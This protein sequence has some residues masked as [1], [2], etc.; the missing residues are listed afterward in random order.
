MGRH[1]ALARMMTRT[2]VIGESTEQP[3]R[4]MHLGA[5][6]AGLRV[7]QSKVLQVLDPTRSML[8]EEVQRA[9]N[10][11][12]TPRRTEDGMHMSLGSRSGRCSLRPRAFCPRPSEAA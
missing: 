10:A 2:G 4:V 7:R 6:R 5:L 1:I 11:A 9:A 3:V 8:P 12:A